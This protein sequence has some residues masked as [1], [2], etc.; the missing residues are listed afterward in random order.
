MKNNKPIVIIIL[1]AVLLFLVILNI[2]LNKKQS[3]LE[4]FQSTKQ[5][6]SDSNTEDVFSN[7]YDFT[8]YSR[9]SEKLGDM[10]Q[11]LKDAEKKC[12]DLEY[13]Q[14]QREERDMMRDNDR[15]HKELQEQDKK[16]HE[17]K[18][19]VKYLTIEKKRRDKIN[20]NCMN[21]KQRKLNENYNLVESLN[22]SGF[23]K[24][25]AIDM[26]LNISESEK[27]KNFLSALKQDKSG[28]DNTAPNGNASDKKKCRT[29]RSD[30]VNL[31][32]I[33]K[34]NKCYGCDGDKLKRS[35][36]YINN[37]FN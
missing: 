10:F 34:I 18:E 35:Q 13:Q 19:I 1:M 36:N 37:D 29:K 21:S 6:N 23:L 17:L 11:T 16:I 20:K 2:T 30:E 24:D 8:E 5:V 26:D 14:V 22:D 7:T 3:N 31:D 25:N 4:H 12:E 33:D 27:L 28:V 9:N 15:I 32:D